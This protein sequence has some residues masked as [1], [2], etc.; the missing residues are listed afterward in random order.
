MKRIKH[1]TLLAI[2]LVTAVSCMNEF[3]TPEFATPPF[4]NNEIGEAN[5]T[6]AELKS[7]FSKAIEGNGYQEVKDEIIIEGVVVANDESGNVYKQFVINDTTGAIIIGVN[8]VGLYATMAIGQRVRIDCKGLYVGG[9]GKLAQVGGL[10]NGSI[11]RMNKSLFPKHIRIIGVPD[12]TQPEMTPEV[13]DETFFT[14]ENIK[15]LAKYVR[16]ENVKIEEAIDNTVKWAPE[17]L[18][19]SSNVVE[20]NIKMGKKNIV[21]RMSTYADFAND[22]LPTGNLNINGVLTR[23]N[24]YWQFMISST[25]DIEKIEN[26]N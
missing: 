9:Y 17:E 5:T 23:Y 8:D 20:R 15:T 18:A 25:A 24:N 6:I 21:L 1:I 10:Y 16:L 22:T 2:L 13:I 26:N 12:R 14:S 11:G 19:N 4:G 7:M 3:E